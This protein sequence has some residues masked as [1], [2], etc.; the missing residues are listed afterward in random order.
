MV[1]T[2]STKIGCHTQGIFWTASFDTLDKSLIHVISKI[3]ICSKCQRSIFLFANWSKPY[4][5][6]VHKMSCSPHAFARGQ[7]VNN[8]TIIGR[9]IIRLEV[10]HKLFMSTSKF[11]ATSFQEFQHI[12]RSVLLQ[13]RNTRWIIET[14]TLAIYNKHNCKLVGRGTAV[15]GPQNMLFPWVNKW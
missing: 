6:P 7:P 1:F 8:E 2:T 5:I 10:R 12:C 11:E 13:F 15:Q 3:I 4:H 14:L 9:S